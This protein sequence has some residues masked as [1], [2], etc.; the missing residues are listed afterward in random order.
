VIV[1]NKNRIVK[2]LDNALIV[3]TP[4]AAISGGKGIVNSL[5]INI[6]KGAPGGCGISNLYALDINSPQS[7]K[8]A[9]ASIVDKYVKVAIANIAHPVRLL[10]RLKLIVWV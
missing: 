6:N 4:R 2:E 9:V 5:A 8:L 1:Q 3:F 7:Q 10:M